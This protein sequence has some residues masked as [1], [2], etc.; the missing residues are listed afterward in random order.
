[1]SGFQTSRH[2]NEKSRRGG[3]PESIRP[4]RL[5]RQQASRQ[6]RVA[7]HL[8]FRPAFIVRHGKGQTI[9]VY[10]HSSIWFCIT[11]LVAFDASTTSSH[12]GHSQ[13]YMRRLVMAC[14]AKSR[15]P[16]SLPRNRRSPPRFEA[17]FSL[18][19]IIKMHDQGGTE[20]IHPSP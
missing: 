19:G 20:P 13:I 12:C 6:S 14:R 9:A 8:V 11:H 16:N 3:T 10:R 4:R 18:W 2:K 1:V 5:T 7:V 15:R 17:G